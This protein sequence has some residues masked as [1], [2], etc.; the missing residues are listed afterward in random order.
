LNVIA[1]LLAFGAP[2]AAFAFG[3]RAGRRASIIGLAVSIAIVL[4]ASLVS[5]WML[6]QQAPG[7]WPLYDDN[8]WPFALGIGAL[9]SALAL[10]GPSVFRA[11]QPALLLSLAIVLALIIPQ[12]PMLFVVC[13]LFGACI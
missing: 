10:V 13:V 1:A 5:R 4:L 11:W 8:P 12:I 6:A 3:V 9:L 2:L 7:G